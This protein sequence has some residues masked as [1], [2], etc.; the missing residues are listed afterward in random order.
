MSDPEA[1]VVIPTY[2][3]G[4][5]IT[6]TLNCLEKQT[7][8][9][10]EVVIINDGS[11][12]N[13]QEV[14]S[15]YIS[16]HPDLRLRLINQK[17]KGIA[18]ARNR[19]ILEAKG[20]YIAFLDHDDIWYPEKL[21]TCCAILTEY[22]QIDLVCHNELMRD[23][24]GRVLA[25]LK[26]GPCAPDMFRKLLFKGNCLSTSATVVRK[27][28]L[29]ETGLFLERQDFST[30]EDYDLWLRLAKKYKFYFIKEILGE[31][32]INQQSASS[33]FERH[34]TNQ[35]RML[36]VNFLEYDEKKAGDCYLIN[37]KILKCYLLIAR[38]TLR[39]ADLK[40]AFNYLWK[41]FL[42]FFYWNKS[43]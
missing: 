37:L 14:I 34:Y 6:K 42:Q 22:P 24:S 23:E 18:G 36:R 39:K 5:F 21:K 2:N 8:N 25:E 26:Y 43:I 38:E 13:T 12:D 31:Y 3:S 11:T 15:E 41:A 30:I 4:G 35:I 27:K 16:E 19:G 33:D 10:F 32:I 29:L 9:S 17:N 40:K 1:S 28:A 7:F 20:R